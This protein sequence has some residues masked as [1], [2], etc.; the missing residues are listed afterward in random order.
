MESTHSTT[1]RAFYPDGTDYAPA[2]PSTPGWDLGPE[3]RI[4]DGQTLARGLGW[5]SIGLGLAELIAPEQLAKFL[6]IDRDEHRGL[7]RFMG[8]R[9]IASGVITLVQREPKTGMWSRV[10]GDAI[11]LAALGAALKE[12]DAKHRVGI[13]AGMVA[14]VAAADVLAAKQLQEH[15]R[16]GNAEREGQR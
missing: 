14:G 11:D 15:D 8:I 12:S 9:E 13:A 3:R 5:F 7:I 1:P 10:A 2:N 16:S 4:D 6:G